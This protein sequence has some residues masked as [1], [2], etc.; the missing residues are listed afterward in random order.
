[1][2]GEVLPCPFCDNRDLEM[3]P[4]EGVAQFVIS[5][6]ECKGNIA[7]PTQLETIEAWNR[8]DWTGD[9]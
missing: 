9:D 2:S 6:H 4:V 8:R 5:C 7:G 1:M 3:Y